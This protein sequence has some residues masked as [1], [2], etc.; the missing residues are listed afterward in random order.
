M[1]Q[2]PT[3]NPETLHKEAREI[4]EQKKTP[5][6]APERELSEA[7]KSTKEE[8]IKETER[9]QTQASNDAISQSANDLLSM[10][11]QAQLSELIKLTFSKGVA[12]AL[13]VARKLEN[14][15]VLDTFHDLLA[16]D[17]LYY[18]LINDK[19]V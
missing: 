13:D 5:E 11:D 15:L 7:E 4:Y 3:L 1:V 17:E 2:E 19:K 14:P 12:F 6:K 9:V 18:K 8:I 16:R 10:D